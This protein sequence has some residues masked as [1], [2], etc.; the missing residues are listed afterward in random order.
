MKKGD[1]EIF[2]RANP[3]R[4]FA[5]TMA[6]TSEDNDQAKP[7]HIP[8]LP[9]NTFSTI[10]YGSFPLILY[11]KEEHHK[12]HSLDFKCGIPIKKLQQFGIGN[13][14]IEANKGL[15]SQSAEELLES[16]ATDPKLTYGDKQ[17]HTK[18]QAPRFVP[19]YV[20][21]DK[22]VCSYCNPDLSR[23]CDIMPT[24]KRLFMRARSSIT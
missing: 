10:V 23:F 24:S 19:A 6:T 11:Q 2:A 9:G 16:L 21:L 7:V 13:E 12:P 5:T 17:F 22:V 3:S 1:F 20:A 15:F 14:P 4:V 8:F 18:A